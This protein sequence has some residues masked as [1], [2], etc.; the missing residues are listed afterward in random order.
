MA[1]KLPEQIFVKHEGECDNAYLSAAEE[2]VAFAEIGEKNIVG[3]YRLVETREVEGVVVIR[4]A[5]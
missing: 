5:E 3:V 1:E 2:I 4:P